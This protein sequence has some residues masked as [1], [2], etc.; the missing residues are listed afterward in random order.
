MLLDEGRL[1]GLL[2]V[3]ADRS[4]LT[5]VFIVTDADESFRAMAAE[6]REALGKQN[7]GLQVLQLYRD[8]LVNF[9]INAGDAT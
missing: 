4:G 1:S 9:L 2:R 3:L 6:V 5:H 7:F 8:Y